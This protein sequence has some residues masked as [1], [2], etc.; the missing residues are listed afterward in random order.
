MDGLRNH[1]IG[2]I[3]VGMVLTAGIALAATNKKSSGILPQEITLSGKYYDRTSLLNEFLNIAFEKYADERPDLYHAMPDSKK[4]IFPKSLYAGDDEWPSTLRL[5]MPANFAQQYPWLYEYIYRDLGSPRM[6][7]LNKWKRSVKVSVGYPF[8]LN[9]QQSGVNE[10]LDYEEVDM[11]QKQEV[12]VED[13]VKK[14]APILRDLTDLPVDYIPHKSETI[15][16]FANLRVIFTDASRFETAFKKGGVSW[17][18]AYARNIGP[19]ARYFRMEIEPLL[20]TSVKFTSRQ[21]DQVDGYFLT[22]ANNEIEYSFC[23]LSDRHEQSLLRALVKEC[24]L[25]SMGLPE[26]T[27]RQKKALLSAWTSVGK[28]YPSFTDFDRYMLWILYN[29]RLKPGMSRI[30]ATRKLLG[31]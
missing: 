14:L 31:Y 18:K 7:S 1:I 27:S 12:L 10:F 24:V 20:T 25:R 28:P 4:T 19:P 23:F 30:E 17:A 13:E 6:L 8:E 29:P 9:A 11:Q 2:L 21:K 16:N 26:N 3:C 15:Q 5:F 22:N